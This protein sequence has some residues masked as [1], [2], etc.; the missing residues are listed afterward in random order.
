[1]ARLAQT[2]K[3]LSPIVAAFRLWLDVIDNRR[4]THDAVA[5]THAAQRLGS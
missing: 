4:S 1:M 2:L 3:V 5:L